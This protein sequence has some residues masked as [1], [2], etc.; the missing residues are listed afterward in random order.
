MGHFNRKGLLKNFMDEKPKTTPD[1]NFYVLVENTF[2]E[3]SSLST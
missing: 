3:R 2:S 1:L